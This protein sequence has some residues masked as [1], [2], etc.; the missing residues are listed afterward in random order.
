MSDLNL[1]NVPEPLIRDLKV[2]AAACSMTLREMCIDWLQSAVDQAQAASAKQQNKHAVKAAP[3]PL[4]AM[5][6]PE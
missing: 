4:P 3:K 5:E 1:R 2:E 6:V